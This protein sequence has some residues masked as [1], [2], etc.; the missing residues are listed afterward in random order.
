M[1]SSKREI[2]YIKADSENRRK[3]KGKKLICWLFVDLVVAATVIALLLHRPGGYD[4]A[5]FDAAGYESGQV[6]PYLTHELS[7]QIYNGAQR[8]KPFNLVITQ[9]GI[10]EIVASWG[11]PKMSHG[12]MLHSPAVLFKAGSVLLMG[13][14]DLKGAELIVTIKIE[15]QI[16]DEGMLSFRVTKVKVGA[17]NITPLARVTAERMYAQKVAGLPIDREAFQTKIAESLLNGAPF[18]PVFKVD[19]RKLRIATI[20]VERQRL[21]A[22]LVPAS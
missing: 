13:T 12:V 4:P 6:S 16:D 11:W 14:A 7:P 17:M 21:V 9:E 3:R 10:N 20:A 2:R 5:D 22:R 8:E 15:P 1:V 18:D 19:G